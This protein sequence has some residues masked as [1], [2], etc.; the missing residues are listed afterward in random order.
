MN[1]TTTHKPTR[2]SFSLLH[3]LCNLIP[4]HLVPKLARDTG[5]AA[6]ARTFTPWSHVVSLLYAQ[7]THA[8]GL[9]DVCDALRLHWDRSRP[10]AA[11]PRPAR[12]PS[13]PPTGN[14]P[15]KWPKNSSMRSSAIWKN[16]TPVLAG[17]AVR[18]LLSASNA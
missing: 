12:T 8:I 5:V 9:N 15:L 4:A 16:F 3:Q 1:K 10:C 7:L 17:I 18:V 14:A 13:P 6:R 2:S 11:R